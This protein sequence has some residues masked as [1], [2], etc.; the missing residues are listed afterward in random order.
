MLDVKSDPATG[1]L[2]LTVNGA[3]GKAEFEKAAAAVDELL[4]T[5][6][7]INVVEIVKAFGWVEAEVWWKDIM[8]HLTHS[9]FIHRAAVV[10]DKGWIGPLTRVFAGFYPAAIRTFH[11]GELEAAREW[12]KSN[13][14]DD[15][16]DDPAQDNGLPDGFA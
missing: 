15:M 1:Y 5:H 8:F 7:R 6:D 16:Q 4:K 11:S 14:R 9:D 3:I 12:V 10:T 13:R 2:E